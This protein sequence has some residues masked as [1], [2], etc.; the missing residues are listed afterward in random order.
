MSSA[1]SRSSKQ[2]GIAILSNPEDLHAFAVQAALRRK[3][4]SAVIIHA[5]DFPQRMRVAV[6]EDTDESSFVLLSSGCRGL[7][8]MPGT[9]WWRRPVPPVVPSTL[10]SEDMAFAIDECNYFVCAFWEVLAREPC[11]WVNPHSTRTS[12]ENKILQLRAAVKAGLRIP[13]TLFTNDPHEMRAFFREHRGGTVYKTFRPT[14]A[15]W[16]SPSGEPQT[17]FTSPVCRADL[18]DDDIASATPGIFQARVPKAFELRV[19]G[20]GRQL[21]AVRIDAPEGSRGRIDWRSAYGEITVSSF[22]L[23][24]E[25][26]AALFKV[27]EILG[28]VTGSFDLIVTP[29]GE[30][31]FLEVNPAGQFLWVEAFAGLP[32][33]DAFSE[34]LISRDPGYTWHQ[35]KRCIRYEDVRPEAEERQRQARLVHVAPILWK[36]V[37]PLLQPQTA[38]P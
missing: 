37:P 26:G 6:R 16:V 2:T 32:L 17:I 13:Q 7:S 38:R 18:P 34:F 3:R 1:R 20:M 19:M 31:V 25:I 15:R 23:P 14:N 5:S 4:S 27:L 33:L 12:A 9:V 11:F 22:P 36:Q 21:F 29:E 28:I 30:Y 24:A 8:S 10:H 35:R